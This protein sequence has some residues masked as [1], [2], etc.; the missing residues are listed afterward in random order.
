M[1]TAYSRYGTAVLED[2]VFIIGGFLG[3]G[4]EAEA[5]RKKILKLDLNT[6]VL[7]NFSVLP[8][9]KSGARSAI[10]DGFLF[11]FGGSENYYGDIPT[12]TIY[13][14]NVSDPSEIEVF[15]MD[16]DIDLTY[17]AVNEHLIYVAGSKIIKDDNGVITGRTFTM[18]AFDTVTNEYKTIAT[19]LGNPS[20]YATIHQ[21]SILED[22][23]YILFG[24]N[25]KIAS[26]GTNP[27]SGFE[28]W[29]V[30]AAP[31]N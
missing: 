24:D 9:P 10:V 28:I 2:N 22:K 3:N 5:N 18:G 12:R 4:S 17:V 14:V 29:E 19:N 1:A 11:V 23:M 31:L 21:M 26:P 25:D 20:G 7:D 16:V 15:E 6:G 8:E 13:K 27:F 30:L